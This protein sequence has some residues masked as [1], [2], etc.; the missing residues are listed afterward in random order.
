MTHAKMWKHVGG[1][2][3]DEADAAM[4]AA[5]YTTPMIGALA[6]NPKVT[7][8]DVIKAASGWVSE[9]KIQASKAID[10]ISQMPDEPDKLRPWLK[11]LY[12]A[13]LSGLVHLKAAQM[14]TQQPSAPAQPGPAQAAAPPQAGAPAMPAPGV[15]Q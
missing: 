13:N 9:G 8:K 4:T 14:A 10:I 11:N 3:P 5:S 6:S 15:P 1:M 2:A 12:A 7:R